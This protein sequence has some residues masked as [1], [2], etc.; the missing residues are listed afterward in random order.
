[1]RVLD[2]FLNKL[3]SKNKK[4]SFALD[5]L[6]LKLVPYLNF[7]NGFFVEAG[8]NDGIEQSNTLYFE[9]YMEWTGILVEPIKEL[10]AQCGINRPRCIVENCALVSLEYEM[11][12]IEMQYCNL[13]SVVRGSLPPQEEKIYIE[14][15]CEVQGIST[16]SLRV[17]ARTLTSVLDKYRVNKLDF[18]SLDVE[19]YE[20]NVL[21]GINFNKY[22]P[23]FMLIEVRSNEIE[24]FLRPIYKPV[25]TLSHHANYHDVLFKRSAAL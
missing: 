18:L 25:T 8:A 15:G 10:A 9:K 22:R 19:G 16:Y 4:E 11:E 13:M 23:T 12:F 7:R 24:N 20:L 21:K 14:Q 3:R 1:M 17:P 2:G 5:Q 6:D